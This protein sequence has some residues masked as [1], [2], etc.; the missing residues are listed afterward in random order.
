M[1]T[2]RLFIA[3][4]T[5]MLGHSP[6][7]QAKTSHARSLAWAG[8]FLRGRAR[9]HLGGWGWRRYLQLALLGD[10]VP[11]LG[12]DSE[13]PRSPL[14]ERPPPQ[15]H[16]GHSHWL[17]NWVQNGVGP[18]WGECSPGSSRPVLTK[19]LIFQVPPRRGVGCHSVS[20]S[21]GDP[22]P[23]LY[24]AR[25]PECLHNLTRKGEVHTSRRTTDPFLSQVPGLF[26]FMFLIQAEKTN[27]QK[28]GLPP[29]EQLNLL[30]I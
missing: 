10:S 4:P 9:P 3:S 1:D 7:N 22:F 17:G 24:A 6:R 30:F 23:C 13:L 26:A 16:K 11:F 8:S 14:L 27:K 25:R 5:S 18:G 19:G 20:G 12:E 28:Q 21:I 15:L 29:V 2:P